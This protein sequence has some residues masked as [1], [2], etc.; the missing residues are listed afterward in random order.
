M[1]KV[2]VLSDNSYLSFE[3]KKIVDKLSIVDY[4]FDYAISPFSNSKDFHVCVDVYDLKKDEDVKNI[5]SNYI[6]VFSIHCKQIFP[7]ELVKSI[8]C[9]NIHPGYNPINR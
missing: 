3:F 6:L 8:K 9:I 2:L 7:I 5:I 1:N 4:L